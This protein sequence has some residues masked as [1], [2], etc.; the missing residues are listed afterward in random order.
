MVDVTTLSTDQ[1]EQ[2]IKE[3]VKQLC[4]NTELSSHLVDIKLR[5][6]QLMQEELRGRGKEVSNV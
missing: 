1:L 2:K 3:S 5:E 4:Q 6:V